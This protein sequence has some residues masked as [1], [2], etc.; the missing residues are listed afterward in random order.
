LKTVSVHAF[1]NVVRREGSCLGSL[2]LTLAMFACVP[3]A[4][5]G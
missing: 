4:A 1:C 2:T 5:F 3:H